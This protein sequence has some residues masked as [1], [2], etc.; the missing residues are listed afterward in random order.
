[1]YNVHIDE[2]CLFFGSRRNRYG[3]VGHGCVRKR[4]GRAHKGGGRFCHG[5]GCGG[6]K[7]RLCV[8]WIG[9]VQVPG[10]KTF[11]FFRLYSFYPDRAISSGE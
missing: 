11:A 8:E 5:V 10:G 4:F 7:S 1:M 2:G 9:W 6:V 3:G